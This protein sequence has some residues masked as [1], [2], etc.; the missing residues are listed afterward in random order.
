MIS[1]SRNKKNLD[2]GLYFVPIS[3]RIP[4]NL[5]Y[6]F[7]DVHLTENGAEKISDLLFSYI[8]DN[9]NLNKL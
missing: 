4:P 6:L 3:K 7:D 2:S 5:N 9:I 8:V 1:N